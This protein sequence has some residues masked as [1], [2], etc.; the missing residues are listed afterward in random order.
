MKDLKDYRNN[1]LK[2]YV[3][4]NIL[5][6]LFLSGAFVELKKLGIENIFDL[7]KSVLESALLSSVIYIY[8]FILDSIIPGD[9]KQKL[10]YF[11]VGKMPGYTIFSDMKKKLRDDRFT[12]ESILDKYK[13]IYEKMPNDKKEKMQ[14][15]N[16]EWY[17]IYQ[18]YKN[19]SK[20]F[21]A[22]RDFLLCRDM[23]VI[24]IWLLVLYVTFTLWFNI[25]TFSWN[26]IIFLFVEIFL[27]N[28]AMRGKARRLAYNVISEDITK[29][30]EE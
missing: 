4:G 9:Y 17:K 12:K 15:E 1:E 24:T 26:N 5:L 19:E 27:T 8:T 20:I 21:V 25:I 22:N 23:N 11:F 30:N 29:L 7:I 18:A 28:I 6:L 3:I 14:F 10:A 2:N 13:K 16:A